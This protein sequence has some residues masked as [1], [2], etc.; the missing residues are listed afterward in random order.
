MVNKLLRQAWTKSNF[1]RWSTSGKYHL[2]NSGIKRITST[3]L[4]EPKKAFVKSGI[5]RLGLSISWNKDKF[6]I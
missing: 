1:S 4:Y 6:K 5:S 3:V 2:S